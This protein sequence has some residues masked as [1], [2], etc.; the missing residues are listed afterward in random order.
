MP[1]GTRGK[2][3][4][5]SIAQEADLRRVV[6]DLDDAKAIE[7]LDLAPTVAELEEAAV[8]SSG[9]GDRIDREGHQLTGKVARIYEILV[10]DDED[11]TGP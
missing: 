1:G 3:D 5:A 8:W 10:R 11:E 7:I 2:P 6:A 9:E 4:P